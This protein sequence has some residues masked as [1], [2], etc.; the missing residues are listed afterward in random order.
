M[1]IETW[2]LILFSMH[3]RNHSC[4]GQPR[5][6][7]LHQ[8]T[9]P[10]MPDCSP[11]NRED[12]IS[13]TVEQVVI[14]IHLQK[15]RGHA[16]ALLM[17]CSVAAFS[18]SL[19]PLQALSADACRARPKENVRIQGLARGQLLMALRWTEASSSL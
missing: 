10:D 8:C 15:I 12:I 9:S 6:S 14:I 2:L 7:Y 11:V 19:C 1:L 18:F 16:S 17:N 5:H 4:A 13:G 3:D